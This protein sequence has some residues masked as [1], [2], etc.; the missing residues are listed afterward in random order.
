MALTTDF[1]ILVS[2]KGGGDQGRKEKRPLFFTVLHTIPKQI[3]D[4]SQSIG[5]NEKTRKNGLM[6][7][8][9]L[10]SQISHDRWL[11]IF[12]AFVDSL[13]LFFSF[14]V[15]SLFGFS[16]YSISFLFI[17]FVY[18]FFHIFWWETSSEWDFI[19]TISYYIKQT[20]KYYYSSLLFFYLILST[21]GYY[22]SLKYDVFSYVK[23]PIEILSSAFNTTN[24][25]IPFLTI[26]TQKKE[27]VKNRFSDEQTY[28]K[29]TET[30]T[31]ENKSYDK[32]K[33]NSNS[34]TY[35]NVINYL[36]IN[37]V[38]LLFCY[39]TFKYS[40]KHFSKKRDINLKGVDVELKTDLEVKIDQLKSVM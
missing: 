7:G 6:S 23:Y 34:I 12:D 35:E 13:F 5:I 31:L 25:S 20:K 1:D 2:H 37:F 3:A 39:S 36:L 28:K 29:E 11:S 4:T 26:E 14:Y 40:T 9:I 27:I 33:E 30:P 32:L 21:F 16:Y 10:P 17:V 18:C 8:V 38:F 22:H 24:L 15:V 19:E